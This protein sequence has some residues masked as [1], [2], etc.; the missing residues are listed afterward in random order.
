MINKTLQE[1]TKKNRPKSKA[2]K[3]RARQFSTKKRLNQKILIEALK[4][5]LGNVS[6]ACEAVGISRVTYYEY[7]KSEDFKT[8]VDSIEEGNLDFA[9]SKLR[10]LMNGVM[11]IDAEGGVYQ[12]RPNP[13]AIIFFLKTKGKKRGYVERQEL[14]AAD[15]K[16]LIPAVVTEKIDKIWGKDAD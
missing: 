9:E 3:D 1:K 8:E 15:G 7:L 11:L 6:A 2:Q 14:T 4:L 13:T 10:E 12:D 5:S 16:D